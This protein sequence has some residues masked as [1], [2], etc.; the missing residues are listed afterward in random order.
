M[1]ASRAVAAMMM[2]WSGVCFAQVRD[3][4]LPVFKAQAEVE[5]KLVAT[6]LAE[7]EKAQDQLR[8]A[9]DR[10]LRLGDDLLRAEREGEDMASFTARVA[11]LRRAE[12][13][14]TQAI[15][16][17]QQLRATLAARRGTLEQLQAEIARLEAGGKPTDEVSGRWQVTIEPGGLKG[18]FDLELSGT[19][20]TGV[21]S[22]AGGWKGSLR[23][24]L[25]GQNLR[26]ERIDAQL[27]FVAVFTG[28]LVT[29][30]DEKRLEGRWDA[31]NLVAGGPVAGTWVARREPAP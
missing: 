20:V 28:R 21:Y 3:P 5:K 23:G 14:L 26:L 1:G 8:A 29:R 18:T 22:L 31:T 17:A 4:V 30:G 9:S 2:V 7:L 13:E 15:A 24:T 27:G 10:V 25:V 6:N 11:D 12:A 16:A 19:I